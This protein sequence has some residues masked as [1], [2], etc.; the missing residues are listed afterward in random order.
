MRVSSNAQW[1]KPDLV[2]FAREGVLMAQRVDR[3]SSAPGR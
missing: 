3:E 1:I 2:V